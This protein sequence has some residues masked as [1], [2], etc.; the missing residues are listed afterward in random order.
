MKGSLRIHRSPLR[1]YTSWLLAL[2][3]VGAATVTGCGGQRILPVE[4]S[5]IPY[6]EE[7]R[8]A[9]DQARSA[10]YRLK[11]GDIIGVSFKYEKQLDTKSLI[12][13]PDGFITLP[14]AE[15][16]KAAGL[17]VGELDSTLTSTF[18]VDYRNPD[19]TVLVHELSALQVYVLGEVNSPGLVKLPEGGLGVLQA[20]ALAGGFKSG[21]QPS[22]TALIR[23][24]DEGFELRRVD[25]S[26]LEKLG[27]PDFGYMDIQPYDVIYVPRST[28]GDIG[29]FNQTVLSPLVNASRIFWDVY[30]IA[31]LDKVERLLR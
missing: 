24:A 17:S 15:G 7:Q 23:V 27:T 26:H 14:G 10:R 1:G 21:A 31:N 2:L 30:A 8:V 9:H 6:S 18:A 5:V 4:T 11:P 12:V 25:L 28:L 22:E 19:L 20:V 3:L 29:F 16:I 13:L